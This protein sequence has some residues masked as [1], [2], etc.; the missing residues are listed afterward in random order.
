MKKKCRILLIFVNIIIFAGLGVCLIGIFNKP[1]AKNI[2][3]SSVQ[4][5]S[6]F[7]TIELYNGNY[8]EI[9][10]NMVNILPSNCTYAPIFTIREYTEKE[11]TAKI[12]QLGELSFN[13]TGRY[14]LT[15]K[16]PT[17]DKYFTKD[18]LVI[19]VV[20]EPKESTSIYINKLQSITM[21]EEDKINLNTIAKVVCPQSA[22]ILVECSPHLSYSN[23]ILTALTAGIG[24]FKVC[25]VYD[26]IIVYK[27][28]NINIKPKLVESDIN[29][30]LNFKN[31]IVV[32]NTIETT[33]SNRS[34]S[35]DYEITNLES[36]Q[37]INCYTDSNIIEILNFDTPTI[38]INTLQRGEAIIYVAPLAYPDAIF[39]IILIIN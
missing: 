25:V 2:Y 10:N 37:Q 36:N 1:K 12:I 17:S 23:Q 28:F 33:L 26:S 9:S 4:F 29:I 5:K 18:N 7:K 6:S 14:V 3:A 21:Y 27:S 13:T 38:V 16:I 8:L 20:D 35:I 24:S 32:N 19:N 15:C 30:I 11:E 39:E 34:L 22:N 31:E